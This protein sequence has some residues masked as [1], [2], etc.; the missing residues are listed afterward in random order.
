MNKTLKNIYLF[1][2]IIMLLNP[3]RI[4]AQNTYSGSYSIQSHYQHWDGN[5]EAG[6]GPHNTIRGIAKYNYIE[7]NEQR[8]VQALSV[9]CEI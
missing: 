5:S 3:A 1:A 8:I 6:I 2:V 4:T 9:F 7:K